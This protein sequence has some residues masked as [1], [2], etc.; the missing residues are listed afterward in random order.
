MWYFC[1]VQCLF[2]VEQPFSSISETVEWSEAGCRVSWVK[3]RIN[4][5]HVILSARLVLLA[6]IAGAAFGRF[7]NQISSSIQTHDPNLHLE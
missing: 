1:L 6:V 5:F 7:E 2:R 3:M 4:T